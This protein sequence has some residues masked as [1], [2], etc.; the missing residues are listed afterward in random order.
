MKVIELN[1][2]MTFMT[3]I[4][5]HGVIELSFYDTDFKNNDGWIHPV[6]FHT[7]NVDNWDENTRCDTIVIENF[8]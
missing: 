7:E 4:N 6:P 1:K 2:K 5:N 3:I 8:G